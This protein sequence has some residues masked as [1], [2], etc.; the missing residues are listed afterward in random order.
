VLWFWSFVGPAAL[1][2][3]L[4]L[5]GERKRAD[6]VT[7]RLTD[8]D[9]PPKD[10]PPVTLIVPV[11]GEADGLAQTLG[12]FAAQDYPDF[13][14]VLVTPAADAIPPGALPPVMKVTIAP[15]A[16][17][18]AL[19]QAGIHAARRRTK[20]FAFGAP[21]GLVSTFWLRA[22]VAPLGEPGVGASTGFRWYTPEPPSFWSLMRSV[23]NSVIAG[24]LGAG[25]SEFAWLGAT[26]ISR[27]VFIGA[28][29]EE[30]WAEAPGDELALATA[31]LNSKLL[32]AFAPGA[33]GA[34]PDR[35]TAPEFLRQ[36]A[37]EMA[38][39]KRHLPGLWWRALLA[40]FFYCGAMLAAVVAILRGSRGAEWALVVLFGLGMLKGANRATLAKAQ[41]PQ[42]KTWFDR[43]SWTHT[44]WVP[45]ATWVWL[46]ALVVSAFTRAE[47]ER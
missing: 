37:Q 14:L 6:Y 7:S 47:A 39:V 45:A 35:T 20:V 5:R 30:R 41:L 25:G 21:D 9:D 17:G 10:A 16:S 13:E 32:V 42:C 24:N 28:H 38:L 31:V 43:Y 36:A 3:A 33:M 40:H 26:A 8:L 34:C 22:L 44:F 11:T 19:L 15:E 2:A 4:A 12:S 29:I 46:Y 1:L 18:V 23:W 27:E